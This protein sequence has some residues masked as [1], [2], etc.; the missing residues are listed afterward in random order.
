[1]D[2]HELSQRIQRGERVR[3]LF[4]W[5]HQPERAGRTGKGCLSQWWPA[6][7]TVDGQTFATAEH[8]MM[9]RKA[10]LFDDPTTA[11]Q[12]LR[13]PHPRRAK[14]LGR[15]VR[16]FDEGVWVEQR[17][18]IVVAGCVAKFGQHADL[19]EF[20]VSTGDRVLVEAS[21]VDPV[22]GIG[23]AADDPRAQD[24]A[25]WLGSNLLGFALTAARATLT[26]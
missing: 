7:F 14:E 8:Y 15:G 2:I 19:R 5:G 4:F 6:Q 24:P 23:L 20:L 13:A 26:T 3:F 22:W 18:D 9:W 10:V 16:G 17:F 21:P 1:M 12:I 11:E 25:Q